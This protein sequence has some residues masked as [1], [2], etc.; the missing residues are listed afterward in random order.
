[1]ELIWKILRKMLKGFCESLVL[2]LSEESLLAVVARETV[3]FAD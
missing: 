2:K 1:M 3:R